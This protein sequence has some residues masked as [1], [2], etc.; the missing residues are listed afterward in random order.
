M[1]YIQMKWYFLMIG[2]TLAKHKVKPQWDTTSYIL[3][4]E[5]YIIKK[6]IIKS[7]GEDLEK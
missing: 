1:Y 4:C 2:Q 7:V 5:K 6:E 3:R